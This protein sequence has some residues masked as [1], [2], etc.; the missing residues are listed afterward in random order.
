METKPCGCGNT[1]VIYS[2]WENQSEPACWECWYMYDP[3]DDYHPDDLSP[4]DWL[5]KENDELP[6]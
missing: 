4:S 1:D 5:P 2:E 3:T 6:F